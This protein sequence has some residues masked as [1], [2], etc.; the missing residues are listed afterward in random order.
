MLV[1]GAQLDRVPTVYVFF[2]SEDH[3][4]SEDQ[5]YRVF[6]PSIKNRFDCDHRVVQMAG[7]YRHRHVANH[8]DTDGIDIISVQRIDMKFRITAGA[9]P[10]VSQFGILEKNP[11]FA[12]TQEFLQ[13]LFQ[14][15]TDKALSQRT[16]S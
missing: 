2:N 9:D 13:G 16:A 5:G 4:Y 3:G 7:L 11:F 10:C 8:W 1:E 12:T 15:R 6:M 14:R